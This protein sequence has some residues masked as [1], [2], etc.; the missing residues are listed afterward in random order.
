MSPEMLMQSGHNRTVD[1]YSL[2]AILYEMI[3]GVPPHYSQNK[4]QMYEQILNDPLTLY[5]IMSKDLQNLFI[6]LLHKDPA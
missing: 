1:Y 5:S 4:E 6:G 2:G 3:I